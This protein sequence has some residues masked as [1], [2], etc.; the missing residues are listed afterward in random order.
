V[1]ASPQGVGSVGARSQWCRWNGSLERPYTLGVEEE[2]LL[3]DAYDH[4]LA[5]VG[6]NV[7]G[8]LSED[9]AV[10]ASPETHAAVIELAT[11]IHQDVG[12]ATAELAALRAKL[13][14]ELR[15]MALCAA[16]AGTYP[17]LSSGD[18]QVSGSERYRMV[19]DSMR[20]LARREPT[21]ALHVHVGIPDAEDAVRVLNGLR[22]AVPVLLAL[23]ANS[24]FSGGQDTGF[25]SARTMIFQAFPRTGT[26]RRFVGYTDYTSALDA[27]IV[28]GALP[29][30]TFLWWD[31]RLQPRL[32]T[33][34][35]RVMDAQSNMADTAALVALVQSL[36]R[37]E[38]EGES[39]DTGIGAEV[40]EE[41]RFLAARDGLDARLI[42]QTNQRLVPARPVLEAL[43]AKCRPH[44]DALG[45]PVELEEVR[46]LMAAN[47][48]DRQRVWARRDGLVGL[49]S[50][51]TR[52]FAASGGR[53]SPTINTARPRRGAA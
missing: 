17:L 32:G 10:C 22:C 14:D 5:P 13:A 41:N 12:A 6:D 11:G 52:R 29:D 26:A 18:D 3:L 50:A 20:A 1:A 51:L 19:S 28:S 31:V 42:D 15:P 44:A 36:A 7:L 16:C 40:L 35:V 45:C 34:E 49:V 53:F 46:R 8:R 24:P 39:I 33:V 23:S 4:S 21:L 25:A 9:L 37:L 43:L 47:G 38:L 2:I 27:L 30:P 48:A